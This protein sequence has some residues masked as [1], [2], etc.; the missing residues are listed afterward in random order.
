[1][2]LQG[3]IYYPEDN[4]FYHYDQIN[5]TG[6]ADQWPDGVHSDPR[7]SEAT[8][9]T[10]VYASTDRGL[11]WAIWGDLGV[12]SSESDIASLGGR[13]LIAA[14]RHQTVN[15][16]DSPTWL[17]LGSAVGPQYQATGVTFS[18]D[19]VRRTPAQQSSCRAALIWALRT[20]AGC[21]G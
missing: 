20:S 6:C 11:S 13:N 9:F 19:E 18:S 10:A 16:S 4:F 12:W 5:Y 7:R 8:E 2:H 15:A 17:S 1:M 3:T 21:R 14:T